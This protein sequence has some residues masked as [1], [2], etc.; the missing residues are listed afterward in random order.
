[1]C[2]C[3]KKI[4][5]NKN[6]RTHCII[7]AQISGALEG[8]THSCTC[9]SAHAYESSAALVEVKRPQ[10]VSRITKLNTITEFA[11]TTFRATPQ[12]RTYQRRADRKL[13]LHTPPS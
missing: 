1:M 7:Q 4:L 3:G 10:P 11:N 6:P 13:L 2:K 9:N 12:A 5:K 8:C